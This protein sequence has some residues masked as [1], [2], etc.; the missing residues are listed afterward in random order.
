MQKNSKAV[1]IWIGIGV[2]M[3]LIQVILGGVTRLTGSGLSITEWN[4]ITGA[5]PP[6]NEAAWI[7]EFEKYKQTP[8]Y[9]LLNIDCQLG[10]FKFIF[11]WEW[12]HRLWA[13]LIGVVFII[14]FV[15][16]LA[17]KLLKKEM[18][19]PLLIL[20][21]LGALQGAVGW[22]MVASGLTGDAVYVKPTRLALHF[23]FAMVL[24]AYA[25]W[26]FLMLTVQKTDLVANRRIKAFTGWLLALTTIQLVFGALMAGHKA[27]TAAPTWP[28]INGSMVPKSTFSHVPFLLNFI[29]NKITIH[30]VHRNLA[31]LIFVLTCMLVW[32]SYK[33]KTS[34]VTFNRIKIVPLLL[35]ILQVVLGVLALTTSIG[36]MPNHWGAFDWI[37]QLHQVVGML[38]ALSL[39]A[40]FFVTNKK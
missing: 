3:L 17:R 27:A 37:A 30:F 21:L 39:V 22:I 9:Q 25:F 28:D 26:F 20:F 11:F 40:L 33:D 23:I 6:L 10:D 15:F 24:I 31:Y 4:V 16:L 35:V 1:A 32:K 13:R 36:I 18:V 7:R 38:F 2:L 29:D 8:Q 5:I 19:R 12:L 14:G 34:S